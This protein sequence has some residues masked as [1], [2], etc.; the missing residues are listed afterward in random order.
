LTGTGAILAKDT[1]LTGIDITSD[2]AG[3]LTFSQ[4]IAGTS[5]SVDASVTQAITYQTIDAAGPTDSLTV[6]LASG[7]ILNSPSGLTLEDSIFQG[8]GNVT[9]NTNG[10]NAAS[11]TQLNDS[12]LAQL[13]I[14]GAGVDIH[15][16]KDA[17]ATLT[18]IDSS[19]NSFGFGDTAINAPNFTTLSFTESGTGTLTVGPAAGFAENLL[20]SLTLKGAVGVTGLTDSS[21]SGLTV[22][23]GTDNANVALTLTGAK[24]VT[25]TDSITLGNGNDLVIDNSNTGTVN[26]TLGNGLVNNVQAFDATQSTINLGSGGNSVAVGFLP[27]S[28][29]TSSISFAA[30]ATTTQDIVFLGG[31]GASTTHIATISGLNSVASGSDVIVFT[32]DM[33]ATGAVTPVS[34]A[35]V[36]TY[37]LA[38]SLDTTQIKTWVAAA[39]DTVADKGAGLAQHHIASFQ[40]QGNT[41]LVEQSQTTGTTTLGGSDTIVELTGL[42]NV[43]ALSSATA[44][45]LHLLG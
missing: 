31:T 9:F 44:G 33:A 21:I 34:A 29:Y 6:T 12:N 13:T 5:L 43:T 2:A 40:F 24:A 17:G 1:A 14:S 27:P 37:A 41:Y 3:A 39:L 7:A 19:N 11:I 36:G 16:L 45:T 15:T 20:T 26:V 25:V 32:G 35:L 38:L 8:I 23:G 10:S 28:G 4:V 42:V 18:V 30:H 22:A